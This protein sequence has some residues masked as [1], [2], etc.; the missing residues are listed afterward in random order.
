MAESFETAGEK[1]SQIWPMPYCK[2]ENTLLRVVTVAARLKAA[3]VVSGG[4]DGGEKM[5]GERREEEKCMFHCS[6][7]LLRSPASLASFKHVVMS[8]YVGQKGAVQMW[9]ETARGAI[10]IFSFAQ[11][12]TGF[13]ARREGVRGVKYFGGG[14]GVCK[15]VK[16][17]CWGHHGHMAL[18][19]D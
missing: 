6:H 9:T 11:R 12:R 19:C 10:S 7:T 14:C 17:A 13:R 4:A 16:N 5:K 18:P 3:E 15:I 2:I 8:S 1:N